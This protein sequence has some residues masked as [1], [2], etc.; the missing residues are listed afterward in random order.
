MPSSP[1]NQRTLGLTAG[2]GLTPAL[3]AR[4]PGGALE[5]NNSSERTLLKVFSTQTK[6]MFAVGEESPKKAKTLSVL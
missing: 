4:Q 5:L 6:R 2:A 3:S 1:S